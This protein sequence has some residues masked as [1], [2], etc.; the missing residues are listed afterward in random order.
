[1]TS[2]RFAFP[3]LAVFACADTEP[4]PAA[5]S[6]TPE[7][8]SAPR[9]EASTSPSTPPPSRD[10][11]NEPVTD[12]GSDAEA[13]A[14]AP[15]EPVTFDL[16]TYNIAGLPQGVSGSNPAVNT[17]LISPLLEPFPLV[18]V[19]EDFTYHADLIASVTH[20][21]QTE[22]VALADRSDGLNMLSRFPFSEFARTTWKDCNGYIDQANDC[23]TKKGFTRAVLDLGQGRLVDVYNVHF[24]AG[25]SD[26]DRA[27]RKKQ[28]VQLTAAITSSS[29]GRPLLVA[30]DTNMKDADE[31]EF[32]QLLDD[33]GL[34][35]ACRVLACPEAARIDRILFRSSSALTLTPLTYALEEQF[36]D[37]DGAP[38][39][40]HAAVSVHFEAR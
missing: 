2:L 31:A 10:A 21:Y 33:A 8:H 16:L 38:L 18:L 14:P 32:T 19:Q 39:S 30:G 36:V 3:L 24:D 22:T 23:L 12:A 9:S 34:S 4:T 11:G 13:D 27:A 29:S 7:Q 37:A 26:G 35:C 1:M 20:P 28:V 15:L 5:P 25:R 40:D 6:S 17:A